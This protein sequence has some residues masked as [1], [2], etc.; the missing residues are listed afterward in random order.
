MEEGT[1]DDFSNLQQ[2]I[3]CNGFDL[4]I[5]FTFTETLFLSFLRCVVSFLASNHQKMYKIW[6]DLLVSLKQLVSLP[7]TPLLPEN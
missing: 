3:D 5:M 1:P 6:L 7:L 2:F 4:N